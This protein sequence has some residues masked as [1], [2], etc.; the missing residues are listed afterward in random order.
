MKKEIIALLIAILIFYGLVSFIMLS[1]NV[2]EWHYLG[3]VALVFGI[4]Y[5]IKEVEEA[6]NK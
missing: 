3:R 1:F 5:S 2:Y 6:S 4:L